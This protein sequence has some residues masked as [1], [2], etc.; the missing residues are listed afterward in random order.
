MRMFQSA[1]PA[2]AATP[3]SRSWTAPAC[4]NPRRPHGRRPGATTRRE[5]G[6]GVSIR[7]ARTGGDRRYAGAL[8]EAT[9]CFNPRRPHGRRHAL[10]RRESS[11]TFEF[12]SA[13]PARA[14]TNRP[15][16][17]PG[18]PRFNPRR[19]HGRRPARLPVPPR[20]PKRFQSAPPAR[21]AT[22]RRSPER[23]GASPV[24]IRA[25]RTGGDRTIR[26]AAPAAVLFQS[27]PPARAATGVSNP[28]RPH[29]RRPPILFLLRPIPR[30]GHL[31]E[32]RSSE[33]TARFSRSVVR[34]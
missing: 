20:T 11:A 2:R 8:C 7:A 22:R 1:P 30:L 3:S 15:R 24:S 21:A 5:A 26:R 25:A 6:E 12:Q 34:L 18:D 13:P 29:G 33:G 31:R 23:P 28:R 4:F 10:S 9:S 19:P 14:A 17:G 16:T 32:P 27:A